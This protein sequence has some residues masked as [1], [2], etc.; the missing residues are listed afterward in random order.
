MLLKRGVNGTFRNL[1]E[2][3]LYHYLA[4]FDLRHNRNHVSDTERA[5]TMLQ[6]AKGKRLHYWQPDEIAHT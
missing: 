4:G 3:H 1:S 6:A 2:A 5:D